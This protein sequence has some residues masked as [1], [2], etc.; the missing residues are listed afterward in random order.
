VAMPLI[1][2]APTSWMRGLNC[3]FNRRNT[4]CYRS[5]VLGTL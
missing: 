3:N 4:L 2:Q 1:G 5:S